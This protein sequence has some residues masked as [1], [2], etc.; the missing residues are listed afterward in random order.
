MLSHLVASGDGSRSYLFLVNYSG[1]DAEAVTVHVPGN[2]GRATLHTPGVAPKA[3]EIYSI[4]DGTGI[5][6][7]RFG[8]TGVLELE[9]RK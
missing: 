3:V 8:V 4:E 9:K 2:F 1:H 7:A 6:I 5:D